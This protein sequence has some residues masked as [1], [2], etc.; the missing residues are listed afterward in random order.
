MGGVD[1]A[2]QLRQY[3]HVRSKSR[4][5]YLYIFWFLFDA[6]IINSFILWKNF[7]ALTDISLRQQS[8]K[9][10]RLSLANKLVGTYNSRQRYSLPL[11][12]RNASTNC[13]PPV[14]KRQ[15]LS[16][17]HSQ[18]EG[19]FPIKGTRGR[20]VFRWNFREERHETCIRCRKCGKALCVESRD[21]DG[22]SC[23]ERYHQNL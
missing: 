2:D 3:Y 8:I 19:H 20:C 9:F 23:F 6:S 5:F 14:T 16:G 17:G 21:S 15:R 13:T 12:I 4:K 10:F 22:L 7:S 18:S 11:S 1:R